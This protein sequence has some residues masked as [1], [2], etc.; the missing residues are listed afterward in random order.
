MQTLFEGR[1]AVRTMSR[2]PKAATK[3]AV[4]AVLQ[5]V[6]PVVADHG[7]YFLVRGIHHPDSRIDHRGFLGGSDWGKSRD[8]VI[9]ATLELLRREIMD[10]DVDG[11]VAEVGVSVGRVAVTLNR[12]FP[13]RMI[14]LFDTFSGFDPRDLAVEAARGRSSVPYP[15]RQATVAQVRSRLPHPEKAKFRVGWFPESA[16]GCEDESFCL[17]NVDVGLYQPT[18]AAMQWFYPRL[19]DGGYLLVND[20]NNAHC[21]G[22]REAVHQFGRET[23][24]AYTVLPDYGAHAVIA[25]PRPQLLGAAR[26]DSASAVPQIGVRT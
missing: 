8:M 9:H 23:G 10:W 16:V 11:A 14:Y 2:Y 13:E 24:A 26:V 15:V 17:V 6:L 25:K 4:F 5:R 3:H 20:Y 22:V 12:L 21:A 7:N 19:S 1:Q 18:L